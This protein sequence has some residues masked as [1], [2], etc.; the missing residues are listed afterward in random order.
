MKNLLVTLLG[1]QTIPN[2]QF[3]KEK[4]NE[5][6]HFLFIRT[7][8]TK[9]D[10]VENWIMG[11][12]N[13]SPDNSTTIDVDAFSIQD[14]ER[15]LNEIDFDIYDKKTVNVTGGTKIMS[16]AVTDFFKDLASDIYYLNGAENTIL[17]VHPKTK[18]QPRPIQKS[19]NLREYIESHGF[20]LK[21]GHLS[22][23]SMEYTKR[24]L[25]CFLDKIVTVDIITILRALRNDK[26][27]QFAIADYDRLSDFLKKIEFPLS[28]KNQEFISRMEVKYL[29]GD[30][31][32]E[33]IY[34]RIKEEL[35][36]SDEFIKTG[37][38]LTKNN[39]INEFD[40]VFLYNGT[41]Y[42]IECKTSILNA[43]QNIMLE[44]IYKVTALQKQLGL[45]SKFS[46]FTL[47]SKENKEVKEAHLDRGKLFGIDVF[48]KEDI[49][50]CESISKLLKLIPC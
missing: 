46:I 7:D 39:T 15:K 49:L 36:I 6:T 22:G 43:E 33:Y 29:T 35:N 30:W 17:Q 8:K 4:Q 44:T 41:L 25:N 12:C 13:I 40:V 27:K 47:S 19:I 18:A 26:K 48:C 42:T 34:N 10:E 45:F 38:T 32:E 5:D 37:I 11:V 1:G 50:E 28:D 23:I 14:I 9:K 3:I 2:V 24:F 20:V 16:H 31:F 21:E